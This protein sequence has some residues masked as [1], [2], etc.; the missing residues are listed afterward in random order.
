MRT[1][2]GVV[3]LHLL[4][5]DVSQVTLSH[6]CNPSV[7]WI[8]VTSLPI[9]AGCWDNALFCLLVRFLIMSAGEREGT[10]L[11]H[12]KKNGREVHDIIKRWFRWSITRN[13]PFKV[14]LQETKVDKVG[15]QTFPGAGSYLAAV[16][17]FSISLLWSQSHKS[18]DQSSPLPSSGCISFTCSNS[19]LKL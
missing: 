9:R 17:L 15:W 19:N 16:L 11:L 7:T 1:Y 10:T 12:Q 14:T 6:F 2:S 13:A 3:S 5:T 4:G 18:W 8:T